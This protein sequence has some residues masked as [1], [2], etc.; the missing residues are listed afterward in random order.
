MKKYLEELAQN[1][2]YTYK[3]VTSFLHQ[4]Y[5]NLF[6]VTFI[7]HFAYFTKLIITMMIISS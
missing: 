1:E 2:I 6:M 4:K 5:Q 3:Y 7:S